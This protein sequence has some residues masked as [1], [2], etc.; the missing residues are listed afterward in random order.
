[1]RI[2]PSRAL[3][4]APT[5]WNQDDFEWSRM[6][7]SWPH[8]QGAYRTTYRRPQRRHT[9]SARACTTDNR[10]LRTAEAIQS[11]LTQGR[12]HDWLRAEEAAGLQNPMEV[13]ARGGEELKPGYERG[14]HA[15][16]VVQFLDRG[17]KGRRLC[18]SES[19]RGE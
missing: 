14:A 15:A 8:F 3:K 1:M 7:S 16:G 2:M 12:P 18:V 5:G 10:P 6:A 11:A 13:A 4:R 19:L 9:P 17:P